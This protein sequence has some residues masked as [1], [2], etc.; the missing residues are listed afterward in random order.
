MRA[1]DADAFR[2]DLMAAIEVPILNM[3]RPSS[4]ASAYESCVRALDRVS[5]LDYA[6]VRHGEWEKHTYW[7]GSWGENQM[8]CN[9]C[10]KKY[11]F[12]AEYNYCPNCGAKMDG[13]KEHG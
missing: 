12:H 3:I 10:S 4:W 11:A 9:K 13:G 7:I 5:T 6:P 2:A 8:I 1:I